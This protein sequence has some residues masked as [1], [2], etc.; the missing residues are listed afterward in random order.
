MLTIA[1]LMY[2]R[3]GLLVKI[4]EKS[5]DSDGIENIMDSFKIIG[6]DVAL[7]FEVHGTAN[8]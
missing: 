2:V 5:N 4:L 6:G 8:R 7:I 3:Y 1:L